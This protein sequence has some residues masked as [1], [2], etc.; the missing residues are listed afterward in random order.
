[1]IYIIKCFTIFVF[2]KMELVQKGTKKLGGVH[3]CEQ[4]LKKLLC[5]RREIFAIMGDNTQD[6]EPGQ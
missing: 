6:K 4:T 1:M 3:I 5:A 2:G